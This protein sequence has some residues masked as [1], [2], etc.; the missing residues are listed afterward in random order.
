MAATPVK[1]F[2]EA[3]YLQACN[4]D[5]GCP[6]E[7]EAPPTPGFC[8]GMG[9]YRI[10]KGKFGDVALDGL[11]FA[12]ALTFPAA[13]HK[14]NGTLVLFFDEKATP[15]QREA[16]QT[17]TSGKVGGMP[18]VVFGMLFSKILDPIFAPFTFNLNGL[19]SSV[20]I[21]SAVS[22]Q[23][24]PIKNPI[25]G[26]AESIRIEHATGFIFKGADVVSAKENLLKSPG[27]NFSYPDK[28]GFVTKIKYG[29]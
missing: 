15:K 3:D 29:N 18:F 25:T 16:L 12:F 6:C 4:C 2:I 17:I 7:F 22:V 14:G 28:A 8:E 10:N 5:Y 21:G 26:D 24:E 13:M 27:M 11:A 23:M 9:A 1:W 19:N 20:K